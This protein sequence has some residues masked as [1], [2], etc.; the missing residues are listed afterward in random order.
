[1]LVLR[2]VTK[3]VVR[4]CRERRSV[5]EAAR[6]I[7][8]SNESG[9]RSQRRGIE[10]GRNIRSIQPR[11]HVS[12][13]NYSS[14]SKLSRKRKPAGESF[15]TAE[16]ALRQLSAVSGRS[17]FRWVFGHLARGTGPGAARARCGPGA[18]SADRVSTR[19]DAICQCQCFRKAERNALEVGK[20]TL[21]LQHSQFTNELCVSIIVACAVC[22]II[23]CIWLIK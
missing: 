12:E 22:S 19:D 10:C 17:G 8:R 7:E 11:L 9:R 3:V 18:R 14:R 6:H 5:F 20:Q 23:A 16:R 4:A 13:H 21:Q 1:M 15:G 2:N